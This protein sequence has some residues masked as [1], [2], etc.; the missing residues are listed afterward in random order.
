MFLC[1]IV[2]LLFW[3]VE[4]NECE[5]RVKIKTPKII[6]KNILTALQNLGP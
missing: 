3:R 5:N 4:K 2:V 6:F 1:N